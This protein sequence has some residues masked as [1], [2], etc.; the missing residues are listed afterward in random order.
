MCYQCFRWR[1]SKN[2]ENKIYIYQYFIFYCSSGFKVGTPAA[3]S[4]SASIAGVLAI[5]TCLQA[6]A[7]RSGRQV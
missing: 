6:L 5:V 2:F 4:I 7:Y 3:I 1:L